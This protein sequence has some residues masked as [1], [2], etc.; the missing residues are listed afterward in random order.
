MNNKVKIGLAL[1]AGGAL[2]FLSLKKKN[3]K[4]PKTFTAPDGNSYKEN[5]LYRTFEGKVY[6]N[7]KE[8]HFNTPESEQK[9]SSTG[10][11]FN[12]TNENALKNYQAIYKDIQYHRKV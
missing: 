8:F 9:I 5:Q 12:E 6:K 4:K 10:N 1:L 3:G 11:H 7:G 2:A